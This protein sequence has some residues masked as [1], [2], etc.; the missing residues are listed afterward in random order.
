M[1]ENL[2]VDEKFFLITTFMQSIINF[3]N[4]LIYLD[5]LIKKRKK[6]KF[7]AYILIE[8]CLRIIIIKFQEEKCSNLS[9]TFKYNHLTITE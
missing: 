5:V 1:T 2:F 7:S 9:E 8:K 6:Q 3:E 4:I